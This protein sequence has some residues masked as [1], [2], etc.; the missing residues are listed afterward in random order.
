MAFDGL[1]PERPV[2]PPWADGPLRLRWHHAT[3]RSKGFG[4]PRT[5]SHRFASAHMGPATFV[6]LTGCW[7]TAIAVLVLVVLVLRWIV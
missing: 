4:R 1:I 2:G 5:P 3:W 7:A 6:W